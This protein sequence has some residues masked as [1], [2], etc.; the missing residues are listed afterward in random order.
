[1]SVQQLHKLSVKDSSGLIEVIHCLDCVEENTV[2]IFYTRR[3]QNNTRLCTC[4]TGATWRP[5]MTI[6]GADNYRMGEVTWLRQ[7]RNYLL[8]IISSICCLCQDVWGEH[9][10]QAYTTRIKHFRIFMIQAFGFYR[11]EPVRIVR[12][13]VI[14]F[15][16]QV[17]FPTGGVDS[18]SE[19]ARAVPE[20]ESVWFVR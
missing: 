18:R 12:L 6:F 4:C 10:R 17:R 9:L 16:C 7:I 20:N 19:S 3:S 11:M 15:L 1:M 13:G 5:R 8:Q 14:V 2:Y